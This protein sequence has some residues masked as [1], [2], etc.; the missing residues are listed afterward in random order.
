MIQEIM[1][2]CLILDT[3][4]NSPPFQTPQ[5]TP[6]CWQLRSKKKKREVWT[7]LYLWSNKNNDMTTC[8]SNLTRLIHF[9]VGNNLQ[10]QKIGIAYKHTINMQWEWKNAIPDQTIDNTFFTNIA[11]L[12]G[13]GQRGS[14][15][16]LISP[17]PFVLQKVDQ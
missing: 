17:F 7:T 12:I 9:K 1:K 5:T 11:T 2:S 8:I 6:L 14:L 16:I 4:D 10:Y 3:A 13:W 15:N